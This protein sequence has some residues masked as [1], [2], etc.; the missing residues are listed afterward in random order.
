LQFIASIDEI[1]DIKVLEYKILQDEPREMSEGA[2]ANKKEIHEALSKLYALLKA[3]IS[4]IIPEC[5][6]ETIDFADLRDIAYDVADSANVWIRQVEA[7][8][9][10]LDT[11]VAVAGQQSP[12]SI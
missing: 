10:V 5:E 3:W 6:L 1:G 4:H 8:L 9:Q 7:E 11:S 2:G 12:H